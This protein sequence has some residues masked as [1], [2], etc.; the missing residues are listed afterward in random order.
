MFQFILRRVS[1]VIP[2]FFGVTLLTF[3]L[4][5]LV[6]GDPIEIMVGERGIDPVRHAMLRA[7]LGLDKP[8][9]VQYGI[10]IVDVF[11]GDLGKSI[12]TK[13]PVISE[14][15]TLFPATIELSLCAIIFALA[16][17]LPAFDIVQVTCPS[18]KCCTSI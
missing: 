12:V 16:I 10:Y 8:L 1:L 11:Q 4:I 7:Q 9:L 2:I 17:G 18:S 14:F 15:F 6:P 5:R 13:E 3:A